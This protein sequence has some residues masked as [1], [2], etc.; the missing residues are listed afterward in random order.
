MDLENKKMHLF[1]TWRFLQPLTLKIYIDY[2]NSP[3]EQK[4]QFLYYTL[5]M[6]TNL[7]E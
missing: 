5:A 6:H 1:D 4:E 3:K 2:Y 7:N